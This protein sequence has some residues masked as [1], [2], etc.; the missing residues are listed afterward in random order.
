MT[1]PMS[2]PLVIATMA[3]GAIGALAMNI[4]LS[5]EYS[6][7]LH[8][9]RDVQDEY[10][11]I[12]VGGGTSGLTVADRL[13]ESGEHTV[14]VI[15]LGVIANGSSV[16]NVS[17]GAQAFINAS[18]TFNFPSEPQVNLGGRT[19]GV[20]GGVLLGGSSGVNGFQ[21][22]RPQ[23]ADINRWGSY[24]GKC[25]DWNW[26]NLLPYFKKAWQLHPPSEETVDEFGIKY[27]ESYWGTD[28]GIHAMF[29]SFNWPFLKNQMDAYEEI[30]GV[31]FP[32]DSGAGEP[33]A[34]WY[35]H[36]AN[37][38]Q[39]T[40][41]FALS[42]HWTGKAT[43]RDNYETVLGQ[44]VLRV[45][46]EDKVAVG[47]EYVAAGAIN[48]SGARVVSARKEVI[49]AAGTIHTPQILEA[50]GIGGR[51]LLEEAE[52]DVVADLPGVGA[53]FQD[54]PLG[55]GAS[56][57]FTNWDFHPDS[58]DLQKNETFRA[59]AEAE[60]AESRTGPLTIASGNAASFLPFSVIAPS[61][62]EAIASAYEAQ[63]PAAY[64]PVNSDPTLVAGYAA[65]KTRFAAALRA[66]DAAFYN[67]FL[68]GTNT[69]GSST[70]F[71]H[72]L[73]RGTVHINPAD[74]FFA[75]PRVDY[76]ALSNPTDLDIQV[77][78]VKFSRRYFLET[79]LAE[80][81]PV[82]VSPGANVT[83]DEALREALRGLIS[84]TCF[85]PVGTAAMS[86]RELGGVVNEK[87]LVYGVE[88]LSV[89]DASVQPDL[90]GAYTQQPVY[91]IAEKAAD[92][93]KAR[94]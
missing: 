76:R 25:S 71:L 29:P 23:K 24:F 54:R 42:E 9:A 20:V 1:K 73:S 34:F 39:V 3:C 47:V 26:E 82:E 85:H 5:V 50:S 38:E 62:F 57:T 89:I 43:V 92:L 74:P 58:S 27:D 70:V 53:N 13:T 22:H 35:P 65:Q 61:T 88:K 68:R 55:G 52:I 69:E 80:F 31:E 51:V 84:P 77:E 15:E 93:I 75:Q 56:F 32:V 28:G 33:G 63:D 59:E 37:P 46:F 94:A 78:F 17:G 49:V 66:K 48:T 91:A 44:R 21:V 16:N 18:L 4:P 90:P 7:I 11:Y 81:G 6:K 64:L 60:F 67:L 45:L 87:L 86:P 14:L 41:S 36:S 19:V 40:R 79:S 2:L 72:P 12:I 30:E 83:S 8:Q 10:D